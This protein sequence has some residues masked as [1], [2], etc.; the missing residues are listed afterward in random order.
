MTE[1]LSQTWLWPLAGLVIALA[2]A[3]PLVWLVMLDLL[4]SFV[5]G[6]WLLGGVRVD[7]ADLVIAGVALALLVRGRWRRD[8][9]PWRLPGFGLWLAL[10]ALLCAA[11]L[12][13]PENQE[14]LTSPVRAAY[15]LYRY[16][17]KPIL[18]YPV[19]ALLLS[20]PRRAWWALAA[21]V[22]GG[23]VCAAI[24]VPQGYQGLRAAGP[25][26]S[27]NTLGAVLVVPML[28][29]A[30][31]LLCGEGRWR[32]LACGASL[33]LLGRALLFCG[34]RGASLAFCIGAAML[35]WLASR[36]PRIRRRMARAAPW[37]LAGALAAVAVS[38][39]LLA[40][41]N[42]QRFLTLAHPMDEGTLQWRMKLRWPHFWHQ[43]EAHPLLGVGTYVDTRLGTSGNTPHN[44]YL[45]TAVASGLPALGVYL[46]FSLL[47]LYRPLRRLL[48]RGRRR[49][50]TAAVSEGEGE[51]AAAPPR[52]FPAWPEQPAARPPRLPLRSAQAATVAE[53]GLGS[54]VLDALVVAAMAG[55]LVHNFDDT[56]W[57]I[58][59]VARELWL[60]VALALVPPRL[61]APRAP[62][63]AGLRWRVAPAGPGAV[64][65][66]AGPGAMQ[67]PAS[68]GAMQAPAAAAT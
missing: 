22:V 6:Q 8:R 47:A 68:P 52:S 20:E 17:W 32:R 65:I 60:L 28:I 16:C 46:F 44:G 31:G 54:W 30:A 24:A 34:S 41:P 3:A 53:T 64:Q 42:L 1:V 9:L 18:Y 25:F 5:P 21:L 45:A 11:Y 40:S 49:A 58:P 39:G 63:T 62:A 14:H 27:P 36:Q 7:P 61:L 66:S 35:C 38:P 26:T 33:L 51:G 37:A 55:L 59:V 56:V 67:E 57:P 4:L 15:Q 23:D 12:T 29:A 10:G 50:A 48:R 2:L 13:A 43:V 19:A